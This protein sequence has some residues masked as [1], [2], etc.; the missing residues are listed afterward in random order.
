ATGP[1]RHRRL[2]GP[3]RDLTSLPP[4]SAPPVAGGEE[5]RELRPGDRARGPGSAAHRQ[6]L[7]SGS[8]RRG[9]VPPPL[10]GSH[11]RAAAPARVEV[12][13]VL[14]T[15]A[16]ALGGMSFHNVSFSSGEDR[17]VLHD[18]SFDVEPGTRLGIAGASGAGKTTLISLLTRFYDP[19][20]GQ[21]W[22]DG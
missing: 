8:E 14:R 16:R 5:A 12:A 18:I 19:T 7:R 21:I 1:H 20:G 10:W 17:P 9:A 2:T 15:V 22:L 11:E 4:A 3:L 13:P 6:G